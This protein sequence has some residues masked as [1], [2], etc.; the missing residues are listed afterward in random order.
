M[1][2]SID[3]KQSM[4]DQK[5]RLIS[6]GQLHT[7]QWLVIFLSLI[8]TIGAWYFSKQQLSQK[9]EAQFTRE[10]NRT[11][12]LI[13]E[14]LTLY[15]NSLWGAV[16]LI[17]SKS[18]K[19]NHDQWHTYA[20]SLRI[21][22]TYPGINGIGVIFNI[23]PEQLSDYLAQQVLARPSYK[24]HP[25]HQQTE[26]WPITYVE[27]MEPN[28]QAIGLD[29]AFEK[30]RYSGI[31]KAR[32]TGSAQ[33][34]G[35]ITLVQ[36]SQKTPGF[37][38][39]TPF[40]KS[41]SK[42]TTIEERQNNIIGVTYAPFI[43]SKLMQGTLANHKRLVNIKLSDAGNI[44]FEDNT[45]KDENP[46]FT[47][48]ENIE[49]YGRSWDFYIQ[50]GLNFRT[51]T[52][53]NQPLLIL[54]GGILIDCLLLALF[55]FLT[56]ANR[57]ALNYVDQMTQSLSRKT[58]KLEQSNEELRNFAYVA[59]HDLKS[60][61]RGIDQLANWIAEDLDDKELTFDHLTMMRSRVNRME[62]LLDDLLAYA[63]IG[64][65]QHEITSVNSQYELEAILDLMSRPKGFKIEYIGD[66]PTFET[67]VTPFQLIFRNLISNA[68]KHHDNKIEGL[69][70][71]SVEEN[72]TF[73]VFK[74]Q[75]DGPGI[76]QIYH[77]KIFGL[78]QTLKPKD[79]V[80]G[81]GMGLA[82]IRKTVHFY[83][84]D[85]TLDPSSTNGACFVVQWPKVISNDLTI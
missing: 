40:Y 32:D 29:M 5:Q 57:R 70:S 78:Y 10:A 74:V 52:A 13:K 31:K 66:F 68:I 6:G 59:S 71:I 83:E 15:E 65:L 17:D 18:G 26:Y 67:V 36:D 4:V 55:L 8:L 54:V 2:M 30:N 47:R 45:D 72:E 50:S 63:K 7:I 77:E 41:G 9:I 42:P 48:V 56:R 81:S 75:D 82:I 53:N 51:S 33:L 21:N 64:R 79:E 20:T 62:H 23:K 38:F 58:E 60:P 84:G 3:N 85:I 39:Y 76:E 19:I 80:E 35:P 22:D 24:I 61:L 73:Y 44:L 37:L 14:R 34:T 28:K 27:P 11:I 43:M 69:I 1:T 12:E 16:A 49:I 46:L 25:Q